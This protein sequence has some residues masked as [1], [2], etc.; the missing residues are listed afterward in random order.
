MT[1]TKDPTARRIR[2]NRGDGLTA[3]AAIAVGALGAFSYYGGT[4]LRPF[5]HTFGIWLLLVAVVAARQSGWRGALR[6][7]GALGL[8]VVTFFYGKQLYYDILYPG[9]GFPYRVTPTELLFWGTLGLLGGAALG[10]V[11]SR[12]G[13]AGWVAAGASALVMGLLLADAFHW[14]ATWDQDLPM[15]FALAGVIVIGALGH[16]TWGQL[17]RTAVLLVPGTIVGYLVVS[18]PD[19]AQAYFRI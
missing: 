18:A 15:A 13:G 14:Y 1:D 5:A 17:G 10:L 4:F 7:G 9:P 2:L 3:L 11:A 6:G 8:S 16:R 19:W 12:I